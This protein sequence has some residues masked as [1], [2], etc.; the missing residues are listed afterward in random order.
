MCISVRIAARMLALATIAVTA[1]PLL[2]N[3]TQ[4]DPAPGWSGCKGQPIQI[5]TGA[6]PEKDTVGFLCL[7]QDVETTGSTVIRRQ[8]GAWTLAPVG[9]LTG[10]DEHDTY[11]YMRR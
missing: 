10:S 3:A 6:D 2:P 11:G 7:S 8:D 5:G 9:Q 1:G 4:A